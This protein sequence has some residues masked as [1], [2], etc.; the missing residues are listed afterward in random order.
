MSAAFMSAALKSLR[1]VQFAMMGSIVAYAIAGEIVGSAH[2]PANPALD[3]A[4]T[5]MSVLIVGVIFVVRR[6]LVLPSADNLAAH[7]D[8]ALALN[9]WKS[10]Y[11]A[12]YV[13]CETLAVF[14]LVLRFS[15]GNMQQSLP[16]YVGGF[17]LLLFFAPRPPSKS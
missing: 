3:Y 15:G 5:T 12:T 6:T 17:V 10:G 14:G 7:P 1:I 4:F 16:F 11:L 2:R 9:H 13:L 8:D